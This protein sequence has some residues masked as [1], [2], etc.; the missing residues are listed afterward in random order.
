M[1]EAACWAH[2]R[3]KFYDQYELERSPIA[4]QA[5]SRIAALYGIEREIRGCSPQV[6][7]SVRTQRAVP[8]LDSLKPWLEL[9]LGQI[10]VKSGLAKAIKYSLA[11]WRALTR[12]CEDGRIEIGRVEMWRGGRR[13]GLSV[14][15]PFVWRCPKNLTIAPFP[16]PAHRT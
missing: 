8:L 7:R 12:Y 3:R 16:H 14:T 9:T 10:S 15:A 11:H 1:V 5:L 4:E 13:S 2:A 6:R